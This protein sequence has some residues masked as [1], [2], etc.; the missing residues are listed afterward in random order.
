VA[1][2]SAPSGVR[3]QWT[4]PPENLGHA[5]DTADPLGFRAT[6]TRI[7]RRLVPALTQT[8]FRVR[9]FS[10]TCF[11][12]EA[13]HRQPALIDEAI[14]QT[15]LRFEHLVVYAQ[16]LRHVEGKL[17]ENA[18]YS[19]I[20]RAYRNLDDPEL[21]LNK[22]LLL[23]DDL[24][25]GLWGTYRRPAMQL[26]LLDQRWRGSTPAATRATPLGEALARTLDGTAISDPKAARKLVRDP[27]RFTDS[28]RAEYLVAEDT[29]SSTDEEAIA[30]TSALTQYDTARQERDRGRP[31]AALRSAYDAATGDLS[32]ATIDGTLLAQGQARALEEARAL[33]A[34]MNAVE[35]PYRLW[36]TGNT[37]NLKKSVLNDPAWALVATDGEPDI[38]SLRSELQLDGSLTA[39]H[40]HQARLAI[41]RGGEPWE[42]GDPRQGREKLDPVD[43]TMGTIASLFRDGVNPKGPGK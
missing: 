14:D 8:S 24:S 37:A 2:R 9:G 19:G 39:V 17:P 15:F 27:L 3:V 29:G 13:A 1:V 35:R 22:S 33:T 6:A 36:V 20:R 30:L 25:G 34:L 42:Y 32:I 10:L 7:A 40:R 16:C 31:F 41:A 18:R 23:H 11:G 26:G 43:F 28:A 4:T 12:L 38:Q 21:D 5:R